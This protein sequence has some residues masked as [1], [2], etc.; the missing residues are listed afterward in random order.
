MLVRTWRLRYTGPGMVNQE[1]TE[2][3]DVE[4]WEKWR[5]PSCGVSLVA[6]QRRAHKE[7]STLGRTSYQ[8]LMGRFLDRQAIVMALHTVQL[9][10]STYPLPAGL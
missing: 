4:R 9:Y 6:V 8:Y 10:F 1:G 2:H 5:R 7:W 3:P